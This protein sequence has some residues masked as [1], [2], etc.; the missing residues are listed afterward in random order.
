MV[1]MKRRPTVVQVAEHAGVSIATVSRV[2]NDKPTRQETAQRVRDAV[3]AL[4]YVPD[5]VGRALKLGRSLHVAFAVDD[6]SNPVYTQMMSGV[7]EGLRSESANLLVSSTGH[8]VDHLL[9][10]V[11]GLADGHADG[12]IISPLVRT[13]EL[14]QALRNAPVPVVL[15]GRHDPSAGLD[16]VMTDSYRGVDLAFNHLVNTGRRR[17]AL[18]NGPASTSPGRSRR[19]AYL[20][21]CERHDIAPLSI[22]T[23][24]FNVPAGERAFRRLRQSILPDAVLAAN[25]TLAL[26]VVRA[27][28]TDGIR[29]PDDLAVTGI[30]DIEFA[31]VFS[32]TLTTVSLRAR[33]RGQLAA[34]LLLDRMNSPS[35]PPQIASVTPRLIVRE[36]T[37]T[38]GTT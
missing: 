12:L 37:S 35:A 3:S 8:D 21:A 13:S 26:G 24:A 22:A 10:F 25:D 29:V 23:R 18:V 15:I 33:R 16:T 20:D 34:Q 31:R 17:I 1:V 14:V 9:D 38:G 32:P 7:E 6:L 4:G 19:D 2:L 27:A 30:D 11:T 28:L 5:G 36:T